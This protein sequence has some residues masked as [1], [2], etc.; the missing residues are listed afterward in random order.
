VWH[1]LSCPCLVNLSA[2]AF[3]YV[4]A[5]LSLWFL[6][7]LLRLGDTT[8]RVRVQSLVAHACDG[9]IDPASD[10]DGFGDDDDGGVTVLR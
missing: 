3:R 10:V 1:I 4:L 5:G 8:R 9:S 6:D 7:R 2:L